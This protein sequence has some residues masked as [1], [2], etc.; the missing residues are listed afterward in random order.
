MEP[1]ITPAELK[2]TYSIE[3]YQDALKQLAT[4]GLP[5]PEVSSQIAYFTRLR[6]LGSR[7]FSG[8]GLLCRGLPGVCRIVVS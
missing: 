3:H 4:L 8:C 1:P 5:T 2:R 6:S 7:A